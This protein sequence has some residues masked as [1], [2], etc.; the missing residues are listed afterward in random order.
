MA[1]SALQTPAQELIRMLII[2]IFW[3]HLVHFHLLVQPNYGD[4][5][6][7]LVSAKIILKPPSLVSIA[8]PL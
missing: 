4:N 8:S 1:D 5:T 3:A 6:C 2:F 7:P